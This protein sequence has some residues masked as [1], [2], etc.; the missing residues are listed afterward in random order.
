M[1]SN[2]RPSVASVQKRNVNGD[3]KQS[4]QE[5]PKNVSSKM[6]TLSE[7]EG[8]ENFAPGTP[9]PSLPSASSTPLPSAEESAELFNDSP[10]TLPSK[11]RKV[12]EESLSQ[13]RVDDK[14]RTIGE[15]SRSVLFVESPCSSRGKQQPAAK[16]TVN[17]LS[18]ALKK[19]GKGAAS[20]QQNV[21]PAQQQNVPP[22]QP[23][24]EDGDLIDELVNDYGEQVEEA[25][26]QAAPQVGVVLNSVQMAL[27]QGFITQSRKEL[28]ETVLSESRWVKTTLL[29]NIIYTEHNLKDEHEKTQKELEGCKEMIA[30]LESRVVDL[31]NQLSGGV[32]ILGFNTRGKQ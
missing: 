25:E 21:P 24:Q 13:T 32:N 1:R 19:L 10:C 18:K 3:L 15:S 27:I 12:E 2:H 31:E 23:A 26:P 6:F 11:M 28:E 8:K 9:G 14:S 20:Q 4:K 16:M 7:E 30:S 17:D 29:N 22:A 5:P